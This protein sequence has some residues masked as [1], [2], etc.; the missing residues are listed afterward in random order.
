MR[1]ARRYRTYFGKGADRESLRV[2]N[3]DLRS[4]FNA[5]QQDKPLK[6]PPESGN[7]RAAIVGG[8]Y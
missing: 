4:A 6:R 2:L 1:I 5:L 7:A 3:R 8:A